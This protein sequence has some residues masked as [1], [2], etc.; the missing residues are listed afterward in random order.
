MKK[1]IIF[2]AGK[3]AEVVHYYMVNESDYEIAAFTLDKEYIHEN[4]FKGFPVVAFDEIQN[5]FP[6]GQFVMFVALGYQG[7]NSIRTERVRQAKKKGYEMISFVHRDSG[8]PKDTKIG[9]IPGQII[10]SPVSRPRLA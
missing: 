9:E 3:I 7:L 4:D 8:L 10:S 1:V 2:G 6:P 5:E